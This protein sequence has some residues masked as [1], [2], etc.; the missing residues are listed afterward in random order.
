MKKSP[1]I[2]LIGTFGEPRKNIIGGAVTKNLTLLKYF[3][4]NNINF[5]ILNTSY[6][7]TAPI[8]TAIKLFN[9]LFLMSKTHVIISH[10]TP[11]AIKLIITIS[12][13]KALKNFDLTYLVIG[14]TLNARLNEKPSLC[15]HLR[16]CNRIIV[17][18]NSMQKTISQMP[19]QNVKCL[20][21]FKSYDYTPIV[22]KKRVLPIKLVFFSR[23]CKEKGIELA[24]QCVERINND[25]KKILFSLDIY[26]P[27]KK[28]YKSRFTQILNKTGHVISYK[29]ILQTE[30]NK[31]YHILSQYDLMIF[32]TYH[33]GEGF[34]GAIIDSLIAG[35]PIIASD[36]QY[37]NEIVRARQIGRLFKTNNLDD[38]METLIWFNYHINEIEIMKKNC[39]NE[40]K[41]YHVD[42]VIPKLL[43]EMGIYN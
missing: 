31:T 22:T 13:L 24:M 18:T 15:K 36:W 21:N 3:Q 32:P 34:P 9:H 42:N 1:K 33:P 25:N 7:G 4:K 2:L 43:M 29:G 38:L 11:F 19:V 28:E 14:G 17:E 26:G 12:Y 10:S 37:N 27:I 5:R 41:K 35:I 39:I 30:K 8:T 40:A 6:I 16:V 20:P 23:V